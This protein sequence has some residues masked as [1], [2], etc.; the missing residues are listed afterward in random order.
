MRKILPVLVILLVLA[1]CS[2][3][4]TDVVA[5]K[6][7]ILI[8]AGQ[9]Q[10]G[11]RAS[12][13]ELNQSIANY[14]FKRTKIWSVISDGRQNAWLNPGTP[15]YNKTNGWEFFNVNYNQT[16]N[17]DPGYH[18][19]EP[20]F[21]Y[22][23][24]QAHPRDTLYIIK[25]TYGGTPLYQD[26]QNIDWNKNSRN[27]LY[28][29]FYKSYLQPGLSSVTNYIPLGFWWAQGETDGKDSIF[30]NAYY[31]N[32]SDFFGQLYVQVPEIKSFPK[33][34]ALTTYFDPI[35][36]P[37]IYLVRNAEKKYCDIIGNN[38]MLIDCDK[39]QTNSI[40]DK[41]FSA[42]GFEYITSLIFPLMNK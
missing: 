16:F 23:F 35:G 10:A 37:D 19:I 17:Q 6:R 7:Y 5:P 11:G 4:G 25:F 22:T 33:F 42:K 13:A 41:H 40:T 32:L 12:N 15:N 8:V 9:S 14:T 39:A 30:G 26:L 20:S 27:E 36:L 28:D 29:Y 24:E 31:G 38:A 34:I 21:A 18:G 1:A 3:N 2:K